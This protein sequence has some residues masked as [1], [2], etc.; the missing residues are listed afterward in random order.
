VTKWFTIRVP[1]EVKDLLDQLQNYADLQGLPYWRIV[2]RALTYLKNMHQGG[3]K[4][5]EIPRL[6]KAAWYSLKLGIAVGA[7]KAQPDQE[8][9]ERLKEVAFQLRDRLGIDV[10]L[11]IKAAKD[12]VD[13]PTTQRTI[14]LSDVAKMIIGDIIVKFLFQ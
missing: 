11:L 2:S 9:L 13:Q 10:D 3:R 7:L 1:K 12:Y 6:D 14:E 8:K 5:S 4:K